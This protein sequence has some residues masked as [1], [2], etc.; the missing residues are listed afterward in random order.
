MSEVTVTVALGSNQGDPLLQITSALSEM[1]RAFGDRYFQCARTVRSKPLGGPP[2]D[3]Y[4]NTVC[5]FSTS[6]SARACLTV[7]QDLE[8]AHGR[9]RNLHWGPRTL[10]LDLILYG[11]Q[12]IDEP[13]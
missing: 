8:R 3:D 11:E 5:R 13:D 12:V 1:R 7:L 4:L 2:Q 6:L 9:V 10:D